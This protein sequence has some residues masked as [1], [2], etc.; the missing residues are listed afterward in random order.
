ML[1][2]VNISISDVENV[3]DPVS[4][5]IPLPVVSVYA[6]GKRVY[7]SA[8]CRNMDDVLACIYVSTVIW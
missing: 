7:E 3:S 8:K 2:T 1:Y 4:V 6:T 5:P